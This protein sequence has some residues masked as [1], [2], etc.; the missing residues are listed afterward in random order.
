MLVT[1][2]FPGRLAR[3][4]R[5]PEADPQS[6]HGFSDLPH[7]ER[8]VLFALALAS[9]PVDLD[10]VAAIVG[11]ED[12][13]AALLD[14]MTRGLATRRSN[15]A[16]EPSPAS[17]RDRLM[18]MA[19][20]V[21]HPEVMAAR[22]LA[23]SESVG[24]RRVAGDSKALAAHLRAAASRTIE[25]RTRR[26]LLKELFDL[27]G[28]LDDGLDLETT[29]DELGLLTERGELLAQLEGH[30]VVGVRRAFFAV[31]SGQFTGPGGA[32]EQAATAQV[33]I[34]LH[35][36]TR[37]RFWR[38]T[39]LARQALGQYDE[40]RDA[41][42]TAGALLEGDRAAVAHTVHDLGVCALYLGRYAEALPH[43]NRALG[44]KLEFGDRSGARITRQKIGIC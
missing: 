24:A 10:D 42:A 28:R 35:P 40:A 41:F 25:L 26:A 21:E 7:H 20:L 22:A 9:T 15:G 5:N 13:G 27:T 18:T 38:V 14:L 44:L 43:F 33:D 34:S 1:A 37:G 17:W 29:R 31:A 36:Q 11:S 32:I 30:P 4:I 8:R 6:A 23:H 19:P 2:G 39:G 12:V 16:F 3:L